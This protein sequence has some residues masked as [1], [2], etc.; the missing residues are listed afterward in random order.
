[1]DRAVLLVPKDR[2]KILAKDLSVVLN[3]TTLPLVT[4]IAAK[5]RKEI[6]SVRPCRGERG[7]ASD[8]CRCVD[9]RLDPGVGSLE[10]SFER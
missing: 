1:M 10:T 7:S 4:G 5:L 6:S 2:N 3:P 8:F 9:L